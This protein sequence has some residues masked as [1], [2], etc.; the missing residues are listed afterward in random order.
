MLPPHPEA[1]SRFL[2]VLRALRPVVEVPK[3]S[4]AGPFVEPIQKTTGNKPPDPWC[5]SFVAYAGVSSFGDSW[6]LPKTASC[7][8]LYEYGK[9]HGLLVTD[10]QPGDVFLL[11][12]PKLR[13]YAHTGVLTGVLP[14]GKVAT[15]EGNTTND[16]SREGW[17]VLERT[18]TLKPE[19]AILRW[20]R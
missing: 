3:A 11:W 18:R 12:Y 2:A 9:K 13:R 1:V 4:N 6:P 20:I 10:P 17:R 19:D 14:D 16:G 7:Q 15:V 5:A 8:A